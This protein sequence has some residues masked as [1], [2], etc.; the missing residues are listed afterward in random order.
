MTTSEWYIDQLEIK[1]KNKIS[2]PVYVEIAD[3]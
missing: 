2:L 3:L 1:K